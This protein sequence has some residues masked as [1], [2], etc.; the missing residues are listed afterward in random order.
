MAMAMAKPYLLLFFS[1][2]MK[3]KNPF[4]SQFCSSYPPIPPIPIIT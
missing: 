1:A 4:F 2:M 3:K